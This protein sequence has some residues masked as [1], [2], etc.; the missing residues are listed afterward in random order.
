M[1]VAL[2][3]LLLLVGIV[4]DL[5]GIGGVNDDIA[6]WGRVWAKYHEFVSNPIVLVALFAIGN[7]L[8]IISA[9]QWLTGRQIAKAGGLTKREFPVRLENWDRVQS[10]P[11]WQIA[12]LW[13][14]LEPHGSDKGMAE[15][16]PAYSAFRFLKE[17]LSQ[18][19]IDGVQKRDGSWAWANIERQQLIDYAL[20]LDDFP[21]FL[22]PIARRFWPIRLLRRLS[23]NE[24]PY[25]NLVL[26][27]DLSEFE[28][29]ITERLSKSNNTVL[30]SDVWSTIK[31]WIGCQEFEAV[32][33]R[34]SRGLLYQYEI[35]PWW[36]WEYMQRNFHGVQWADEIYFD[37]KV[38]QLTESSSGHATRKMPGS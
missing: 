33:R 30:T 2:R 23:R 31:T 3:S 34:K 8:I 19:L 26:Y 4:L 24:I 12:W 29:E 21:K 16:T 6:S 7:G 10:F 35:I 28:N 22:F 1:F 11:V 13:N 32:G 25:R 37:V 15:G 5:I 14:D 9:T 20:L 38:R 27:Q 36:K 18:G 17:H